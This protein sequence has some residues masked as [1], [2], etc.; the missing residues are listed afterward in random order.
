[1][2]E[3]FYSDVINIRDS[4]KVPG[5]IHSVDTYLGRYFRRYLMQKVCSVFDINGMPDKWKEQHVDEYVKYCLFGWGSVAVFNTN[6]FGVIPQACGYYGYNVF[7]RPTHAVVSNPLF[8]KTYRLKINEECAVIRLSPDWCGIADLI[9]HYADLMALVASAIVSN[10]Y[11]ARLA[12]VFTADNQAMGESFKKMFDKICEGNPAVFADRKLFGED[13]SP[14]WAAFQQN[15]KQVYLVD[16]LQAAE[17]AVEVDFYAQIGVPNVNFEKKE[18]LLVS[19]ISSNR[20]A[21]Q[22]LASLWLRTLNATSEKANELFG[23]DLK[24]DY[25][26]ELKEQLEMQKEAEEMATNPAKQQGPNAGNSGSKGGKQN[27]V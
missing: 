15:L 4:R 25:T 14:R 26:A 22:C 5:T 27:G 9:G 7:Y 18:R 12:Y 24:F 17:Q 16:V 13:G 8:D 11:N 6:K 21:T 23:L 3:P 19:E 1:M 20:F 10:L 2:Y